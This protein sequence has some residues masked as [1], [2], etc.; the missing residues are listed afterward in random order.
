MNRRGEAIAVV[1]STLV[2]SDAQNLNFAVPIRYAYGILARSTEAVPFR[3]FIST[4]DFSNASRDA[5]SRSEESNALFDDASPEVI[6]FLSELP[7]WRQQVYL[8]LNRDSLYL[9]PLLGL[10]ISGDS[11]GWQFLASGQ[12]YISTITLE[13]GDY[14]ASGV[15]DDDCIDFDISV[16]DENLEFLNSD[17]DINPEPFVAFTV[18]NT[19]QYS[20]EATMHE[21]T[22]ED[23]LYAIQL[24][25]TN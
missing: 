12:S 25:K 7:V 3:D 20:I 16:Y 15:C 17:T 13:A 9:A 2:S 1:T 21:C 4:V 22:T 23:C 8:R 10:E 11:F 5:P 18:R 24:Y 19:A 6:E 14:Y